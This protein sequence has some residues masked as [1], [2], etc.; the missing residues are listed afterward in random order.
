MNDIL[1][2]YEKPLHW[3]V[4]LALLWQNSVRVAGNFTNN[5]LIIFKCLTDIECFRPTGRLRT[6]TLK[7]FIDNILAY[8]L[9]KKVSCTGRVSINM[10]TSIYQML[11]WQ[12]R[13]NKSETWEWKR[14]KKAAPQERDVEFEVHSFVNYTKGKPAISLWIED[15]KMS[16]TNMAKPPQVIQSFFYCQ[17]TLQVWNKRKAAKK[18]KNIFPNERAQFATMWTSYKDLP[19]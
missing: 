2:Q 14:E 3:N 1:R 18:K 5:S 12:S 10:F 6:G 15:R 13:E 4:I 16:L 19:P 11:R 8:N 7:D 17:K 9:V